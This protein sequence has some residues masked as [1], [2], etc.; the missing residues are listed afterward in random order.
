MVVIK[1]EVDQNAGGFGL[2]VIK[3]HVSHIS[4]S[5]PLIDT[6]TPT[7]PPLPP[8]LASYHF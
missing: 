6:I 5:C 8:Q 1:V 2:V 4:Y 7:P 3:V